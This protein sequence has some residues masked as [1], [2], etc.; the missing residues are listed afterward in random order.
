MRLVAS[1]RR[2]AESKPPYGR[3]S[4]A[5]FT[6]A[7][8]CGG[9]LPFQVFSP[10]FDHS[11][12]FARSANYTSG[13]TDPAHGCGNS[14][15]TP[16]DEFVKSFSQVTSCAPAGGTPYDLGQIECRPLDFADRTVP[17]AADLDLA[18]HR[19]DSTVNH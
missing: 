17:E 19:S 9:G 8:R 3:L 14:G 2:Y 16:F 18:D 10:D 5:T 1:K 7:L 4:R 6:Y 13:L 12:P 11:S 15:G